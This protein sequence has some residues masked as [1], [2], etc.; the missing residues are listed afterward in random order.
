LQLALVQRPHLGTNPVIDIEMLR[1][2]RTVNSS[3]KGKARMPPIGG[4]SHMPFAV[5]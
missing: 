2:M 5:H 1:A 3:A 4:Q